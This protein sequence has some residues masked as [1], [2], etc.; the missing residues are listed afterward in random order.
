MKQLI[1]V[2]AVSL[3]ILMNVSTTTAQAPASA[4]LENI[5]PTTTRVLTG[6][7]TGSGIMVDRSGLVLTVAHTIGDRKNLKFNQTVFVV[8]DEQPLVA[9][10]IILL[11]L[12]QDLA[13]IQIPAGNY[14][15][16]IP[17]R[18]VFLGMPVYA[19]GFPLNLP[20]LPAITHGIVSKQF[21]E[22]GT[23]IIQTDV[24]INLG[25][26]GGPLIDTQGGVV[27]MVSS[28]LSTPETG[29]PT[30]GISFAISISTI[31]EFLDKY[32]GRNVCPDWKSI[33]R[34]APAP[35]QC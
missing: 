12:K 2:I 7:V 4:I 25:N 16:A 19:V 11:D 17:A 35:T 8:V 1:A 29:P 33:L 20:G 9:G 18:K 22:N 13:L 21:R 30:V 28:I 32:Q 6:T 14:R 34:D 10:T 26:S 5:L 3:L 31:L 23:D 27:G 15:S 24:L